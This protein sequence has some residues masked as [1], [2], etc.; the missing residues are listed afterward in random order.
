MAMTLASVRAVDDIGGIS[1]AEIHIGLMILI[2]LATV[3]S[4][5]L[6]VCILLLTVPLAA[7][8]FRKKIAALGTAANTRA[9][10]S[11]PQPGPRHMASNPASRFPREQVAAVETPMQAPHWGS[12]RRQVHAGHLPNADHAAPSVNLTSRST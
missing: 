7:L 11:A 10:Q 8:V 4:A 9:P 1:S 12:D 6:A 2:V 5:F 3:L